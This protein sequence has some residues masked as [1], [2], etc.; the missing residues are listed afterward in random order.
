MMKIITP[1]F[2]ICSLLSAQG[3]FEQGMGKSVPVMGEG[4]NTE[5]RIYSK[6][7]LAETSWFAKLLRGISKY[8]T[9]V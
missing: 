5:A 1:P 4:K 3:Q 8:T 6:E 9:T 2:F 7:L